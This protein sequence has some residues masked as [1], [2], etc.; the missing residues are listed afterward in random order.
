MWGNEI[1]V[2]V[3]RRTAEGHVGSMSIRRRDRRSPRDWRHFQAIKDQLA[4]PDAEAVELYPAQNRL[5]DTANQFWLWCL[6]PGERFPLGFNERRVR[7]AVSEQDETGA[8]QRPFD[9]G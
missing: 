2:V 4:G 3:V 8:A 9:D 7:D 6:P 5:V 1:Y